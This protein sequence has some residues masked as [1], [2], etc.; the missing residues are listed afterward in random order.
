MTEL[1]EES[2]L[3]NEMRNYAKTNHIPIIAPEGASLLLQAILARQPHVI[4]EIGSAIAYST[5]LMAMCMPPGA[6]IITI[7]INDDRI[8]TAQEYI[9]R[10]GFASRIQLI[11]GDAA[12]VLPTLQGSFDFV[13]IDAAKGQ[14]LDYLNKIKTRLAPQ[15][16]IIADNVLFRG[17]V[18]SDAKPPRRFK[19]I[20]KRLRDYLHFV[21]T[22]PEFTTQTYEHGDGLAISYYQRSE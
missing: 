18:R 22:H 9:A 8:E 15:A 4:L 20:V 10:S 2:Y 16:T 7:E 19:T 14:Y 17:M 13:F 6:S 11:Q 12:V 5:L 3:L 1:F 21:T